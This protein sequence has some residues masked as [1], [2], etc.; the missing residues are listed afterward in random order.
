[1]LVPAAAT[2]LAAALACTPAGRPLVAEVYYD[3]PGDDTAWEFVELYNPLPQATSLAGLRLQAGDGAGPGR[4]TL[5]WTGGPLDS[6]RAGGRFV[7]G[8][9][10]LSPP[11]DAI[12][13]LELQNGPDAMRLLWP[14][15]ATEVVGWGA[16]AYP[17]YSCGAP[18]IDV[19]PGQSL[20]RVPDDAQ[21]GS[22]ALDFR[23]AEPSPGRANRPDVDLAIVRASLAMTPENPA[24]GAAV[25][26]AL[27]LA[28]RGA[29]SLAAGADTLVLAGDALAAP[30]VLPLG[31]IASGETLRVDEAVLAGG[32][33]RRELL[34]GARVTGDAEPGND[35]DTLLVQVGPGALEV[36]EIQFHP[37]AGEGEWI[38]VRNRSSGPLVLSDFTLSDRAD[39]RTPVRDAIA[40]APDSLA[41]LAQ[42][43]AA[44]LAVFSGLDAA[45][46]AGVGAW[47]SLNNANAADGTADIVT[48]RE[49]SGLPSDRVPYSA[50]GVPAGVTLEKRSGGWAPS[51]A[52]GGTPLA[53][54]HAPSVGG[55]GFSAEPRRLRREDPQTHLAWR[56]PWPQ[57]RVSIALYDL[58][59]RRI[60]G[61]LDDVPSAETGERTVRLEGAGPGLYA[62]VL[63]ARSPREALTRSAL[64]RITGARP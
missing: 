39:T 49:R 2:L 46:I 6:I 23:P 41:L 12:V 11:P 62:L 51:S 57:A 16:L 44:L 24:P 26:V 1:M 10:K 3:A 52:P 60:A 33:G 61:L 38:E 27:A 53:P 15:G 42:D 25:H 50:T 4:W 19:A 35:A 30:L 9:A 55:A 37:A 31:A 63:T 40:L 7:I 22:N 17:E 5:R 13:T 8:G 14:D 18:A 54:P 21:L 56:L 47:P 43:R 20:A 28:N 36:T 45:R 48:L 64:V 32:A 29:A 34:A 59:G 58:E